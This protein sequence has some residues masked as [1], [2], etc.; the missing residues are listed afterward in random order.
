MSD[1]SIA[2]ASR[3]GDPVERFWAR[4]IKTDSCWVWT[5]GKRRKGYGKVEWDGLQ[6][7][8]HQVSW[9]L[10]HGPIPDGLHVCHHCD[11]PPCVNPNHLWLGTNRDNHADRA[12]KYW[13][14]VSP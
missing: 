7:G 12:A 1:A 6:R 11:N 9:E 13:K 5:G 8:A 2:R 10:H 14:A 3:W 4:V